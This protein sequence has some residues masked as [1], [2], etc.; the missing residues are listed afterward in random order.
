MR[1][2]MIDKQNVS[3]LVKCTNDRG[4]QYS[5]ELHVYTTCLSYDLLPKCLNMYLKVFANPVHKYIIMIYFAI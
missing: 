4:V 3:I 5:D 1:V 2:T